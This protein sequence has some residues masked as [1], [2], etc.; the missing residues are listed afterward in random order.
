[1][2]ISKNMTDDTTNKASYSSEDKYVSICTS[3]IICI[4]L[5]LH[6]STYVYVIIRHPIR[7]IYQVAR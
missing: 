2:V 1:M 3:L 7:T 6:V 4:K 5:V